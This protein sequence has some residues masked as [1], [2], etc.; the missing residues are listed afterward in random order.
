MINATERMQEFDPSSLDVEN[1][2]EELRMLVA[3]MEDG[4]EV[5]S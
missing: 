5:A 3:C 1:Y 2:N 4:D